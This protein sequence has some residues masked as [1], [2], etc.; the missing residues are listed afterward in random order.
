MPLFQLDIEKRQNDE[1]WTNVYYVNTTDLIQANLLAPTF[2]QAEQEFHYNT[3]LFTK[4]RVRDM[5]PDTDA[6]IITPINT[7]GDLNDPGNQLPLFNVV[8][9]DFPTAGFG[10]PA[11]KYYRT[12]A[13][14]LNITTAR[15]WT[16]AYITLVTDA[17]DGLR[18][19]VLD[20]WK[21]IDGQAILDVSVTPLVGMRQLRR[22]SKRKV[23]PI[24]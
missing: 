9:V 23:N 14:T 4:S 16:G 11:R 15:E 22:G 5:S 7:F 10:R 13:G 19:T 2:V 20:N 12:G 17:L 6:F 1:F 21:D 3:V 8:R 18:A 24:L